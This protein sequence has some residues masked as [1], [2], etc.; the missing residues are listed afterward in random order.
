MTIAPTVPTVPTAPAVPAARRRVP[1]GATA[2]LAVLLLALGACSSSDDDSKTTSKTTSAA[3]TAAT[4][5]AE[6]G[7]EAPNGDATADGSSNVDAPGTTLSAAQASRLSRILFN[8]YEDKGA[9]FTA[10]VPFG[11]G[12]T[13]TLRGQVNWI[14]HQGAAELHTDY[15]DPATADTDLEL[16]WD[17]NGV[18]TRLDQPEGQFEWIGSEFDPKVPL[19]QV[20]LLID[21]VASTKAENPLLV[22]QSGATYLRSETLDGTK[23]EV[24]RYGDNTTYWVE[25]DSARMLKVSAQFRS[26]GNGPVVVTFSDRGEKSITLPDMNTVGQRPTSSTAESTSIAP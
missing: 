21:K 2:T 8:N 19:H 18:Y 11:K 4:A 17:T 5:D 6:A 7:S 12:T 24:F 20:I 23:T 15:A 10:D 22:R 16:T 3:A 26:V 14:T 1:R 9:D 13:F 25:P